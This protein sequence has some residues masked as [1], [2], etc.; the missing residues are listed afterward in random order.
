VRPRG[1]TDWQRTTTLELFSGE[2]TE[3]RRPDFTK[4]HVRLTE[5]LRVSPALRSGGFTP[6]E[7]TAF[8]AGGSAFAH[9]GGVFVNVEAATGRESAKTAL[10]AARALTTMP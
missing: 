9:V 7:G 5:A 10:A 1:A 8:G 3:E 6:P 4:P 2:L